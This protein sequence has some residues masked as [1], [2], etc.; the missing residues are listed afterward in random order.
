MLI[1]RLSFVQRRSFSSARFGLTLPSRTYTICLVHSFTREEESIS[2]QRQKQ[3]D[4]KLGV[5]NTL[6]R[7]G[8]AGIAAA[9][10]ESSGAFATLAAQGLHISSPLL[11]TFVRK[12]QLTDLAAL[13]EDPDRSADFAR[14][15]RAPQ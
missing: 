4:L 10:L 9:L 12:D 5:A 2:P 1:E 6:R 14:T 7:L 11:S 3:G 13:L 8:L 15:L